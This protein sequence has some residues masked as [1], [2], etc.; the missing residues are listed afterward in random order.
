MLTG[1]PPV[2]PPFVEPPP[3]PPAQ[4]DVLAFFGCAAHHAVEPF[5]AFVAFAEAMP[6]SPRRGMA[7]T[8]VSATPRTKLRRTF[9]CSLL[10]V[11]SP[12]HLAVWQGSGQSSELTNN[13][14]SVVI[15]TPSVVKIDHVE[16]RNNHCP[17]PQGPVAAGPESPARVRPGTARWAR[18]GSSG[19]G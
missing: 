15:A 17:S 7:T 13:A 5:A 11:G 1:G 10:V 3:A 9:T 19:P 14:L 6:D 18:R 16:S 4:T 2:P 8:T 12:R